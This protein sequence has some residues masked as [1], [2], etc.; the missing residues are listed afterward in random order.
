MTIN[1]TIADNYAQGP[2]VL[3]RSAARVSE[4]L[5]TP[6]TASTASASPGEVWTITAEADVWVQFG[7]APTGVGPRWRMKAGETRQ[8]FA[9]VAAEKAAYATS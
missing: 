4:T 7:T 2:A 1:I 5:S 3:A 8:W 6:G 9:T